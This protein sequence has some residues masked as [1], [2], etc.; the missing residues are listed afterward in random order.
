VNLRSNKSKLDKLLKPAVAD[1]VP[2]I[3]TVPGDELTGGYRLLVPAGRVA[4][5]S[6]PYEQ[7]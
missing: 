7:E 3:E 6:R 4:W 1:G 2:M 5:W